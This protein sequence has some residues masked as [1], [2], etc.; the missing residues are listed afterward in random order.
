MAASDQPTLNK[1]WASASWERKQEIIADHVYYQRGSFYCLANDPSV[2]EAVRAKFSAYGLCSDEFVDNNY[3]PPQ[4]YVRIS[5][6]L[7]G[8]Y[9]MTQNNIASPRNK[10]DSIAVGDW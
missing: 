3:I 5:N 1:G 8:D 6:R 9:V 7:V 4:L 10:V 2:P